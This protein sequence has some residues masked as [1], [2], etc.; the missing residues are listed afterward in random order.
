M[1]GLPFIARSQ[2][3]GIFNIHVAGSL[4]GRRMLLCPYLWLL[5]VVSLV[6]R[7][8]LILMSVLVL[9]VLVVL[10]VLL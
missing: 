5:I 2:R 3:E 4:N 6:I 10:R 1:H 7:A 9:E 8:L